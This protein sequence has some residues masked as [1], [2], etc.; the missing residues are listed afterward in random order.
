M[1]LHDVSR[2][3]LG[4]GGPAAIFDARFAVVGPGQDNYE[5]L[6]EVCE[7]HHVRRLDIHG[8]S[9]SETDSPTSPSE[10][11]L[12]VE[13]EPLTERE[14]DRMYL[15]LEKALVELFGRE[16][17]LVTTDDIKYEYLRKVIT[18]R[19]TLLYEADDREGS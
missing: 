14:R 6:K 16:V 1:N 5:A 15:A 4:A 17:C 7:R 19:R 18:R 3:D 8:S 9:W 12:L 2:Q 10:L 11:N 13:F